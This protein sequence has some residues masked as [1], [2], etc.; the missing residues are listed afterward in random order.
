M[1]MHRILNHEGRQLHYRDEG[2]ENSNTLVLLHGFM[3]NLDVWTSLVL[4]YMHDMRVI[5]V[6]LPGHGYSSSY[7]DIHTMDFMARCVKAVL[8]YAG[9]EQCVMMGHSMGGYVALSFAEQ[10]PYALRGLGLLH[11]HALADDEEKRQQRMNACEQIHRNRSEYI[12]NFIP[13]LFDQSKQSE[14]EQEIKD[15][16]EQ[17]LET[18]EQSLIAAEQG[19]MRRPHH[20]N[21]LK[22]LH[23]P[24]LFIYGKNDSRLPLEVAVSQAMVPQH[25]EI[26]ILDHVA[27]M[28]HLESREYV[29][30][31]IRDFV[32]VCYL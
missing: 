15:L 7:S 14:L 25:S 3:Q 8:E 1:E 9:V 29:R 24:C 5:T 16:K 21:T 22:R 13:S 6:D 12:L 10:Y 27:H 2:R 11:S 28:A 30:L 4:S 20:I 17:S 26:M 19:M 31:R 32:S 23:V 18:T